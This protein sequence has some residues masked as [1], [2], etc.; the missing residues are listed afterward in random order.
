MQE[1]NALLFPYAFLV[2]VPAVGIYAIVQL[3][4]GPTPVMRL[5]WWA[6]LIPTTFVALVLLLGL[7]AP[8][9]FFR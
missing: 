5:V 7:I 8:F 2:L 9:L 6:L 4:R 3:R 1:I